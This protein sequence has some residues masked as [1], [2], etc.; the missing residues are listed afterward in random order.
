MGIPSFYRRLSVVHKGLIGKQRGNKTAAL[1]FDF[2]CLIY[3]VA[4]RPDMPV[5]TTQTHS[6]WEKT[7]LEKINDYV[8]HVWRQGGEPPEVF[9]AVDGVVP[10]AKIKQQRLRRFKSAW[11]VEEERRLGLRVDN[12]VSWDTNSITPGTAFMEKLGA[13]LRQLCIQKGSGW[14]VSTAE[15]QGEGEQKIMRLLRS[16]SLETYDGSLLIYGLDADL[17]LLSLLNGIGRGFDQCY[18]MREDE[19]FGKKYPGEK[20]SFSYFSLP[21]LAKSLWKDFES[22]NLEQ[23]TRRIVNYV[24]G[25]SLLGNDFLP[26]SL[27]VKVKEDG[28]EV[29]SKCLLAFEA[30]GQFLVEQKN[31][32]WKF[33]REVLQR[34]LELWSEKEEDSILYGIRKKLLLRNTMNLVDAEQ[35]FQHRPSEWAVEKEITRWVKQ[36]DG[37]SRLTFLPTWKETYASVWNKGVSLPTLCEQYLYGLQWILDYYTGQ[38]PVPT[39]WMFP[40]SLPPLWSQLVAF[41]KANPSEPLS[42]ILFWSRIQPQQQLAM[43]LPLSSWYLLRDKHLRQLPLS[44]P[45]FWPREFSFFSVGKTM[46]WECEPDICHLPLSVVLE[47]PVS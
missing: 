46:M 34:L 24:A 23:K 3:H 39:T 37:K 29:L 9:L 12:G 17:I 14:S 44:H 8:V 45:Q 38:Q 26:H 33:N 5:Y 30:E 32:Q 7:L 10:L 2:N 1:Y 13:S 22:L 36:E 25:M 42:Q 35:V 19:E 4:R 27:S 21:V 31:G 43:V 47:K 20:E 15:E 41:L 28:H 40:T 11:L 18:L 6:Q 16:R